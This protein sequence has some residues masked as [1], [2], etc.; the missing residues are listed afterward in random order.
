MNAIILAAGLGSRLR[1]VSGDLP[2]CLVDL[3]GKT[4]L[5]RQLDLLEACNIRETTVVVG[6]QADSIRAAVKGRV[7]FAEYP[8]Y[9]QTNNLHTLQY[10]GQ[11]LSTDSLVLFA[12]VLVETEAMRRCIE[13]PH[14]F[15][16]LVDLANARADTMRIRLAD[17]LIVDLGSHIPVDEAHGNFIGIAKFSQRGAIQLRREL[18]RMVEEMGFERFYYT[19]ALPRLASAAESIH[20]IPV[21]PSRWFEIDGPTDYQHAL[22]EA[23]YLS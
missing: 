7:R 6:H 16:L 3:R 11:L 18:D 10:C 12:D 17:D 4:L 8:Y 19:G 15:S 9:E 23:F 21:G 1:P 14:D 5:Q 22:K 2:K 13:S 20:P